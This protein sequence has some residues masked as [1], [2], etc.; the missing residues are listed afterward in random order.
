[1]QTYTRKELE[2]GNLVKIKNRSNQVSELAALIA[3]GYDENTPNDSVSNSVENVKKSSKDSD[4]NI[5]YSL[6]DNLENVE[7]Y[8]IIIVAY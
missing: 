4:E 6:N 2:N 5:R 3:A 7:K 8:C 1:M